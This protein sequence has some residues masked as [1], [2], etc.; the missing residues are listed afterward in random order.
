MYVS[1]DTF[2][3]L[4]Q[5]AEERLLRELEYRRV[6]KERVADTTPPRERGLRLRARTLR[7]LVHLAPR[8][9]SHT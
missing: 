6:T 7:R 1:E 4:R 3:H 2:P 8:A 9:I 5:A